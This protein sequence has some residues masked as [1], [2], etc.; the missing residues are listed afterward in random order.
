MWPAFSFLV[1]LAFAEPKGKSTPRV[2]LANTES[3]FLVSASVCRWPPLNS[4]ETSVE[5][6]TPTAL[7]STKTL[8]TRS[9]HC[10]K[11]SV[12]YVTKAQ[13]CGWEPG[14]Q[15]LFPGHSRKEFTATPR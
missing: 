7:S 4:P 10:W 8:Q 13:V 6:K 14:R 1:D 9:F 2:T 3:L 11:N 15:K 12:A 5:S